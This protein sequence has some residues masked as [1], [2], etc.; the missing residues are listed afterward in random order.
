MVW[1][2]LLIIVCYFNIVFVNS[3]VSKW[4][5]YSLHIRCW[6]LQYIPNLMKDSEAASLMWLRMIQRYRSIFVW[7][8][9]KQVNTLRKLIF[10]VRS[11]SCEVVMILMVI[12]AYKSCPCLRLW[13]YSVLW[14]CLIPR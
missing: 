7:L 12:S 1:I 3:F 14:T 6:H 10:R 13:N 4:F 8:S 5:I 9:W 11:Y 2:A